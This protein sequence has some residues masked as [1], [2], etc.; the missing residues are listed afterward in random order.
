MREQGLFLHLL[1][2]RELRALNPILGYLNQQREQVLTHLHQQYV[3]HFGAERSLDEASFRA[4]YG[5]DLDAVARN[6]AEGDMEGFSTD[7]RSLGRDL[8]ER[9]VPFPEVVATLHLFEESAGAVYRPFLAS[10]PP[11]DVP[12][13]INVPQAIDKLSHCR[14]ILLASV[15][16]AA[17]KAESDARVHAL[18]GELQRLAPT[19]QRHH[20][21][22]LVGQSAVMQRLYQRLDALT[23][24]SA[25]GR[26]RPSWRPLDDPPSRAVLLVGE[27]GVGKALVA[28]T[29]HERARPGAPF[30]TVTCAALNRQLSEVDLFGPRGPDGP[31]EALGA[32]RA[33]GGTLF[34]D[35]ITELSGEMQHKL[36]RALREA[37]ADAAVHL[38]AATSRDPEKAVNLGLLRPE[39]YALLREQRVNVPPLRERAED[40]PLLIEHFTELLSH[41]GL[42]RVTVVEPE[43]LAVLSSYPWPGNVRELRDA[44]EQALT[45]SQ[46]D[47]LR[48]Q[49][50]P[51]HLLSAV[52]A[53]PAS[54]VVDGVA[55]APPAKVPTMEEAEKD[56][57]VRALAATSGNK[58]QAA[59][60]L[61]ISRHRLYDKLRKFQIEL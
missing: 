61:R 13:D 44:L 18:E 36:Q 20:F 22:G 27:S 10:A 40:L 39:L 25:P 6:L 3:T 50:L 26:A 38:I 52:P 24:D 37:R 29:L 23:Q 1:S 21:G 54:R 16:F 53:A 43:A 55:P 31:G 32:L 19:G 56:L 7:L 14:L 33:A 51:A 45:V 58:L 28:R 35:E 5:R 49:D 11:L 59:R 34:L 42:R 17:A 41:R 60:M 30:V 8:L 9:G 47:T 57:I 46:G 48:R 15:Y 4:F 12:P 2:D